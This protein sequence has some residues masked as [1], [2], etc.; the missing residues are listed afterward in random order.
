MMITEVKALRVTYIYHSGFLI[1]TQKS[2]YVFDYYKGM[3]PAFDVKKPV[4]VFSTHAHQDHY[5]PEIFALLASR[6]AADVS[7]VLAKDIPSRKYPENIHVLT[8]RADMR[9][10]LPMGE[11]VET[12]RSTDSGVAYL[13]TCDEGVIFHAGD[14][15]DWTWDGESDAD[16]R[17][18][19]GSFRHEI[20]KLAARRIDVAFMPLDPRQGEHYADGMLYLLKKTEAACVYPMHYWGKGEVLDRFAAEHP[21]YASRTGNTEAAAQR[22]GPQS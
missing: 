17:Q 18:M 15:N 5:N 14:L 22:R 12:L 16:N 19:R 7:A 8:V 21:E 20:D 6:G 11:T 3:L 13:V 2:V 1:E 4:T 10:T 9:Y